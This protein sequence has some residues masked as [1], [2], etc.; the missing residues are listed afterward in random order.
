M[1]T[2]TTHTEL[3]LEAFSRAVERE[4]VAAVAAW[5][6]DDA[7]WT[8]IDA[9]TPPA[10]PSVL[11]GRAAIEEAV[12]DIAARGITTRVDDAILAGDRAALR[13]VCTY[14]A[15]G[16][17]VEHA[18]IELREGRIARWSGVQAWDE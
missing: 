13:L 15:G 5:F 7:Q 10:S 16:L 6:A 9:R 17:V 12:R 1:T 14:P 11:R 18:L 4:G 8:T 3:D 2:T